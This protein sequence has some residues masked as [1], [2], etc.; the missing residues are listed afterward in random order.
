MIRAALTVALTALVTK[1]AL[2]GLRVPGLERENIKL[3]AEVA[4]L[5]TR[6]L[7]LERRSIVRRIRD[8]LGA[9]L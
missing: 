4:R 2:H 6:C 3:R 9:E 5:V 7:K 1:Y 8:D